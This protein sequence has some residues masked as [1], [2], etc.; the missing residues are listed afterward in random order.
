MTEPTIGQPVSRLKVVGVAAVVVLFLAGVVSA[1][2]ALRYEH[3]TSAAATAPG[4][5]VEPASDP[6][7]PIECEDPIPREG[8]VRATDGGE[9]RL[10]RVSSSSLYDCP[11]TFDG[12]RIRYRG[13]VIGAV[14]RRQDGA[15]VHLNDDIY[16]GEIGPVIAHRDFR[17]GNGGLGVFIPHSLAAQITHFGGPK[18]RGDI[19]EVVGRFHRVDEATG[20]VAILRATEGTVTPGTPLELPFLPARRVVGIAMFLL[21]IGV[22]AA[23]RVFRYRE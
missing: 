4:S 2:E 16:A 7:D 22:V 14:L 6:R 17:G 5:Q 8:Q 1:T 20:E 13:E 18:Q 15:W 23:E 9:R 19:V 11:Q 10:R 12:S 21:M 3:A